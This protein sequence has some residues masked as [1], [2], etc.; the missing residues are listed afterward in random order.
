MENVTSC[1]LI[2][3]PLPEIWKTRVISGKTA[4]SKIWWSSVQ[5]IISTFVPLHPGGPGRP[6]GPSCPGSPWENTTAV[7]QNSKS[8]GRTEQQWAETHYRALQSRNTNT[9]SVHTVISLQYY[10]IDYSRFKDICLNWFYVFRHFM[11]E[12]NKCKLKMKK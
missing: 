4:L 8:C 5:V 3:R 2:P 7:N 10:N 12:L 9:L 11:V 1:Q 6:M